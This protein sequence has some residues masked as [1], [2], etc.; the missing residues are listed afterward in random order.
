MSDISDNV[1]SMSKVKPNSETQITN[2]PSDGGQP[3]VAS[4][5]DNSNAN[6]PKMSDPTRILEDIKS[7]LVDYFESR[8]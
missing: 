4:V 2:P 5:A 8:I 1:D 7:L 6:K 3:V